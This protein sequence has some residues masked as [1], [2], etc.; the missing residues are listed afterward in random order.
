[1]EE[2]RQGCTHR[3]TAPTAQCAVQLSAA[4][5][6]LSWS[7]W[8]KFT[9]TRRR[10]VGVVVQFHALLLVYFLW[11]KSSSKKLY[12]DTDGMVMYR[13]G[14]VPVRLCTGKVLYRYGY[15]PVRLCTGMV[16]YRQGFVPVRLCTGKVL[17]RYG[18]VP[19]RL[20]TG[21]VM[22]RHGYVPVCD[23]SPHHVV[24]PEGI[25]S[26]NCTCDK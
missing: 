25:H 14:F 23:S 1:M 15:V 6:E 16:M 12:Y 8:K 4:T 11:A 22:Y 3:A 19:V 2:P 13:Q 10:I 7:G 17:Y 24:R 18:Y 5:L 26:S 20:C 9:P 21:T